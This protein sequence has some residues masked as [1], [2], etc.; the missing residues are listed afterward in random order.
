MNLTQVSTIDANFPCDIFFKQDTVPSLAIEAGKDTEQVVSEIAGHTLKLRLNEESSERIKVFITL[1][2]LEE[3]HLEN[4]NFVTVSK[5]NAKD[6]KIHLIGT[7][8]LYMNVDAKVLHFEGKG[9]IAA[10]FEGRID[11]QIVQLAGPSFKY[12]AK[13]ALS[14]KVTLDGGDKDMA[15]AENKRT[16]TL[17]TDEAHITR[18]GSKT[19]IFFDHKPTVLDNNSLAELSFGSEE[20]A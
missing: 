9:D 16:I 15:S 17:N 10:S 2:N 8:I 11:E 3:L 4:T 12:L 18:C 7:V 19:T 20:S 6:L 5:L 1:Q 14:T 13:E